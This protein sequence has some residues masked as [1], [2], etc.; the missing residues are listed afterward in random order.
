MAKK[1]RALI[2][3]NRLARRGDADLQPVTASLRG[4]GIATILIRV[5][6][7]EAMNQAIDVYGSRVD[8]IVV[9]GGDGT[10]D[11]SLHALLDS[12]LPLGIL[13]LGTANDL[14]R[15][16]RIPA[17]LSDAAQIIAAGHIRRIDLGLVN[18]RYF[19][20]A[21]SI[22]LAVRVN[23]CLTPEM[24]K[25]WGVAAY[26]MALMDAF[27]N[28]RPF[29]VRVVC[30]GTVHQ[31]KSIQVTIGNGR[32]YGGGMAIRQDAEINDHRL[33]CYNLKPQ[34]LWELLQTAPSIVKGTFED[35]ERVWLMDGSRFEVVTNKP[36][37]IHADGEMKTHTPA[38]FSVQEALLP[39]FVPPEAL[40]AYPPEDR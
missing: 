35:R 33:H 17:S 18:D 25:K 6:D 31:L 9:G 13:P 14:A 1:K 21:A 20:N 37:E 28:N 10:L 26:P 23:H 12:G 30:D 24:K 40:E 36:M 2:V 29:R 19:F 16:L 7:A 15:T 5:G 32:H 4:N 8:R 11:A 38:R 22:G 27:R 3:V 39:V 34:T